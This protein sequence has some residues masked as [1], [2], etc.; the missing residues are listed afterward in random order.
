MT[1]R[2]A[3]VLLAEILELLAPAPGGHWLDGTLGGGGHAEAL[4]MRTAPDGRLLGIDRDP[5]AL[6]RAA[7]RLA[8]YGDRLV[9]AEGNIADLD[10]VADANAWPP[11]N[12]ILFDL[13]ISS[14]QLDDPARGLSF[15]SD[16]PLDMRLGPDA[17][18]TAADWVNDAAEADLADVIWRYGEERASRRIARAIVA[19]RPLRSTRALADV[20]ARVVRPE[21]GRR[22]VHPA[23]R[24]F[25][26]LRI[27]VN[28]EL[29]AVERAVPQA[30]GRLATGGR[31][32]VISFHS[33]EDR[34]IK[35]AFK[36][37]ATGCTCPPEMPLCVCGG[38]PTVRLVTRHP[39]TPT[40]DECR[41]NPRARSAKLRVAERLAEVAA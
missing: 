39:V 38:R 24:T 8:A 21:R 26:A 6:A 40:E 3:P 41:A 20:V 10:A 14:D 12:G 16:G 11:C 2:H 32:A 34:I 23:T 4:L 30:F 33:L 13:G 5:L 27:A 9:L 22:P 17:D 31:L 19:A 35:R 29:S 15:Q 18:M 28:D 25:Q 7:E 37:A 1:T 36:A